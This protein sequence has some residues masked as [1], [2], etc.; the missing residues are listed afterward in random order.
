MGDRLAD[1]GGEVEAAVTVGF[2]EWGGLKRVRLKL[3]DLRPAA[4]RER[5]GA[6]GPVSA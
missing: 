1:C 5:A 6:G 4:A 3:K 2:D